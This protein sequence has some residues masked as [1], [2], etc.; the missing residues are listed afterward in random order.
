METS[1]NEESSASTIQPMVHRTVSRPL[2]FFF[3]KGQIFEI[4]EE[5]EEL[6]SKRFHDHLSLELSCN[7][8]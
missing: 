7:H 1:C 2:C 4:E 5:E 8:M 6:E 3:L